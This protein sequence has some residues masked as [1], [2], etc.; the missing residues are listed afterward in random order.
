MMLSSRNWRRF[1]ELGCRRGILFIV[2]FLWLCGFH[3]WNWL[4]AREIHNR[5]E[6]SDDDIYAALFDEK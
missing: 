1:R 5:C 6:L 3:C 4:L 2:A